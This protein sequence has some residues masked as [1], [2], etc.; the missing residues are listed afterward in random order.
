MVLPAQRLTPRYDVERMK[1]EVAALVDVPRARP[2][3]YATEGWDGIALVQRGGLADDTRS[4]MPSLTGPRPTPALVRCPYLAEVLASL[5]ADVLVARLLF[6]AP[7]GTAGLHRDPIGFPLGVVR[8]HVPIVT[9]PDVE[10]WIANERASWTEGELWF[11]DFRYPHRLANR[12]PITRVHLVVD[13]CVADALLALFPGPV[14]PAV[15][16]PLYK[17]RPRQALSAARLSSFTREITLP[18]MSLPGVT[19]H[20]RLALRVETDEVGALVVAS[21]P[22]DPSFAM[23]LDPLSDRELT[24]RGYFPGVTIERRGDDSLHLVH[25]GRVRLP[26]DAEDETTPWELFTTRWPLP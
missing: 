3:P 13:V 7:N 12:S 10:L 9:H 24:L 5:G 21:A 20:D 14:D 16:G 11:A 15:V 8:L 17:A 18:P 25:R 4:P 2:G 22:S 19:A 26:P 6:L 23:A 1:R